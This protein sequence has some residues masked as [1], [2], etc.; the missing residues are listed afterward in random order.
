MAYAFGAN[1]IEWVYSTDEKFVS[2]LK[3]VT[4]WFGGAV[5]ANASGM[6]QVTRPSDD[7]M[8]KDFDGVSLVPRHM[9][10]WGGAKSTPINHPGRMVT[11]THPETIKVLKEQAKYY[12]TEI[13]ASSLQFDDPM[14]QAYSGSYLGGDFNSYTLAGFNRFLVNYPDKDEL[15]STGIDQMSGDYRE[16]LKSRYGIRGAADYERRY[17]QLPSTSIWLKYLRQ[18]VRAFFQD[19]RT[20]LNHL[21][22]GAKP[23]SLSMNLG[24]LKWP[25]ERESHFFLASLADYAM[26]E[27]PISSTTE[28]ISRAATVRALG[29]GYAP[30]LKPRSLA[31][32]RVAIATF[33]ALGGTP[34][35]PWDVYDGNDEK[36]QAKRFFGRAEEYADLY[37]FPRKHPA[38]FDDQELAPVVGIPIPVHKFNVDATAKLVRRLA[39]Y[40]IPFA[41]ILTGGT[42]D[43]FHVDLER[44]RH[45]RIL[46]AV[47]PDGDF[48]PD[49]LRALQSLPVPSVGASHLTDDELREFS[50]FLAAGEA[51]ALKLYPRTHVKGDGHRLLIHL[52]DEARGDQDSIGRGCR[53]RIGIKK[54]YI[55]EKKIVAATWYSGK[56]LFKLALTA[57]EREIF[58]TVPECRLWGVISLDF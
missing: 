1:R 9:K 14:L 57:S 52:I 54:Q 49:D 12:L 16:F 34:I 7:A 29:I 22:P 28:L 40:R 10:A 47:N 37:H 24:I 48:R 19:F 23:V 8:A 20:Y 41:F 4:P 18:T 58:V 6:P 45:F 30:S 21:K 25:D 3:E 43:K 42:E 31:E 27:T 56:T 32:N 53:R 33:Y 11:T 51:I 38:L 36:G 17:K 50:P 5:N 46:I 2:L 13:G 15:R 26:S 44:T 39:D 35:V 55:G